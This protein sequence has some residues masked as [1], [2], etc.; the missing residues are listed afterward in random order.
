MGLEPIEFAIESGAVCEELRSPK[1]YQKSYIYF[2]DERTFTFPEAA[3]SLCPRGD[4]R[5]AILL[6][7]TQSIADTELFRT[8][9]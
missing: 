8:D 9:S 7:V 6:L 5:R 3:P 4:E 1:Q 2:T